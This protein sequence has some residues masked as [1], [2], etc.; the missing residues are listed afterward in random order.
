MKSKLL[1]LVALFFTAFSINAQITSVAIVGTAVGGW[2]GEAGNPGPL[3]VHQ[4]T[5]SGTDTWT[6]T[7][8]IGVGSCKFRGNNQWWSGATPGEW[9]GPFPTGV[10]VGAG[11]IAVTA[12]GNYTVTLNSATG[13]Y[14]FVAGAPLPIVKII[15][16]AVTPSS[17]L[18]M[19]LQ[20]GS[21]YSVTS[22]LLVGGAQF[23]IDG[24]I[25]GDLAFPT[26][27]LS[28]INSIPVTPASKYKVTLD[29]SN[30]NYTFTAISAVIKITIVGSATPI[31]W[32]DYAGA[33]PELNEIEDT[34][35]M[36]NTDNL[37]E[38]Y[39]FGELPS[40]NV[41]QAL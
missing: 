36:I 17:G 29:I 1:L 8:P 28:G 41:T 27:T 33:T 34:Q 25:A 15:G 4:M 31:G 10:G 26:G 18:E 11:D 12:A 37:N 39:Y 32:P 14:N 22:D 7:L 30:G 6:I 3:D 35:K 16:A 13:E 5:S 24:V 40:T 2:P 9:A 23:D 38:N 19:V 20:S 21:V